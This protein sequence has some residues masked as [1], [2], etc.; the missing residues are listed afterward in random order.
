M[1]SIVLAMQ[2]TEIC[3]IVHKQNGHISPHI[4][5]HNVINCNLEIPI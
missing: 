4:I 1:D 3:L 5:L 2:T